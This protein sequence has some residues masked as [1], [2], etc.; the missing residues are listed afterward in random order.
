METKNLK[1]RRTDMVEVAEKNGVYGRCETCK[2]YQH[3]MTCGECYGGSRYCFA[4]REYA[5][6]VAE[7]NG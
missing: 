7:E 2:H 6:M 3:T 5:E 1:V 4:W